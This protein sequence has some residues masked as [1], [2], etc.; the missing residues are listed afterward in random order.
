[1]KQTSS[2]NNKLHIDN[3][4]FEGQRGEAQSGLYPHLRKVPATS[5]KFRASPSSVH[6]AICCQII[7]AKK[8]VSL[9]LVSRPR[10]SLQTCQNL[11]IL[12]GGQILVQLEDGTEDKALEDFTDSGQ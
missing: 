8:T 10:S 3:K 4:H 9:I 11:E 1:M 6:A 7:R 12:L 5:S 2:Q